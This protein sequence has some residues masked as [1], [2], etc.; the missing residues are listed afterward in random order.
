MVITSHIH[1]WTHTAREHGAASAA[2][3]T[4]ALG[5][6]RYFSIL[7]G[8]DSAQ[9]DETRSRATCFPAYPS[10]TGTTPNTKITNDWCNSEEKNQLFRK[11]THFCL[12]VLP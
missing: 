11:E 3:R 6:K 9:R 4:K 2:D 12:I 5:D 8:E 1:D 7:S 10:F